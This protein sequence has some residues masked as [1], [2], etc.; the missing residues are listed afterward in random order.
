MK[1]AHQ[2]ENKKMAKENRRTTNT[3]MRSKRPSTHICPVTEH[4]TQ[5]VLVVQGAILGRDEVKDSRRWML[6]N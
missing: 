4:S 2:G 1:A 5:I 6:R 3:K